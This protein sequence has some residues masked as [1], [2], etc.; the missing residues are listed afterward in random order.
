MWLDIE[1]LSDLAKCSYI[2][3]SNQL[4]LN[5]ITS[6][7]KSSLILSMMLYHRHKAT[8]SYDPN[9]YKMYWAIEIPN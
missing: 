4:T 3:I 2:F 8:H 7:G 9:K 6:M 1:S 5:V